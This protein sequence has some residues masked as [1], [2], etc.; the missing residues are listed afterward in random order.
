MKNRILIVFVLLIFILSSLFSGCI[1]QS[2]NVPLKYQTIYDS[3]EE[4]LT[5]LHFQLEST[6]DHQKDDVIF[7]TELLAASANRGELIL[8]PEILDGVIYNLNAMVSLG[9]HAVSLDIKYPVLVNGFPRKDEYLTF[10]QNVVD[11]I[12]SRNLILY[13]GVQVAFID[14]VF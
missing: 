6:W 11:E 3:L 8:E 13:M 9:V 2:E 1:H 12:R 14:P 5:D 7:S 10:Y 4:K